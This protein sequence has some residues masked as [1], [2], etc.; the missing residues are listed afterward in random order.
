MKRVLTVSIALF[1][2]MFQQNEANAASF[3]F[4]F[5]M[6]EFTEKGGS[7]DAFTGKTSVLALALDNG[8]S[9]PF[10]E[11][12]AMRDL[13]GA[14]V[15]SIA[16]TN[17][18]GHAARVIGFNNPFDDPSQ[19][20]VTTDKFGKAVLNVVSSSRGAA[21]FSSE[22]NTRYDGYQLAFTGPSRYK[23]CTYSIDIGGKRG[24]LCDGGQPF[25]ASGHLGDALVFPAIVPLP[26]SLPLFLGA[27]GIIACVRMRLGTHQQDNGSISLS[28]V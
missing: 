22:A 11:V 17:V 19:I 13:L 5:D 23:A 9:D 8:S 10:N 6:P 12:F 20:L 1:F 14:Q 18:I 26:A 25:I 28:G 21:L 15:V 3:T 7:Y 4:Y 2:S 16:G 24:G 27:F